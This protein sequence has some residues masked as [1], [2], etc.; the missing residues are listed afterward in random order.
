MS[1]QK[2]IFNSHWQLDKINPYDL[3]LDLHDL[4]LKLNPKETLISVRQDKPYEDVIEYLQEKIRLALRY[5]N[6]YTIQDG[7]KQNY[8]FY[9]VDR[10]F[11]HYAYVLN[12]YEDR[13]HMDIVIEYKFGIFEQHHICLSNT[14]KLSAINPSFGILF[15]KALRYLQ[16]EM[17]N[18]T[19]SY[20]SL[21]KLFKEFKY[22]LVIEKKII[23]SIKEFID[24]SHKT[25]FNMN[26]YSYAVIPAEHMMYTGLSISTCPVPSK[27][28]IINSLSVH[29]VYRPDDIIVKEWTN[30][31]HYGNDVSRRVFDYIREPM[32]YDYLHRLLNLKHYLES[33][34][35]DNYVARCYTKFQASLQ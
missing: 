27:T 8:N 11:V 2:E 32:F 20:R 15:V 17:S 25:K 16:K 7:A 19:I 14:H 6:I 33:K 1:F 9:T 23:D 28:K 26:D 35:F 5:Y 10:V 30:K 34:S 29:K 13:Y 4:L 12:K 22:N 18:D 3:I 31:N 24:F 21:M